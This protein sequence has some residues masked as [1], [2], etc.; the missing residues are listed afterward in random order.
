MNSRYLSELL[1]RAAP[2]GLPTSQ[3]RRAVLRIAAALAASAV[4][5]PLTPRKTWAQPS[6]SAYPFTLGVASGSPRADGAVLW[7]RLAPEPLAD[8][9][10]PR[11]NVELAWELAADEGFRKLVRTGTATATPDLGHSVHIELT[12]LEPARWYWYRFTAG[13]AVS[14]V[15]RTRTAPAQIG[16]ASCRERV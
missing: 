3:R 14:P 6:F 10:M 15:G 2:A 5:A 12:D 9:G 4:L 11:E 7:T 16:R 1:R 13:D 8:G